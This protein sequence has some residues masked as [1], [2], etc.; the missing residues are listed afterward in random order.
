MEAA[1]AGTIE[2]YDQS[3]KPFK[4][5]ADAYK[6]EAEKDF[7]RGRCG[8]DWVKEAARV[9]CKLTEWLG[10]PKIRDATKEVI[11][12]FIDWKL[13]SGAAPGTVN[14]YLKHLS[15]ILSRAVDS[16]VI[17]RHP[18]K[19]IKKPKSNPEVGILTPDELQ[20]LLSKATSILEEREPWFALT[21]T[22]L[23][24]LVWYKPVTEVAKEMGYQTWLLAS[25]VGR[26]A[27][28]LIQKA[29]VKV[30]RLLLTSKPT[31]LTGMTLPIFPPL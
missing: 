14:T 25:A 20:T 6:D 3:N 1:L 27:R 18:M 15:T 9:A 30:P 22:E 12:D 16:G 19:R 2:Y 7:K 23:Q 5:Y 11:Q 31:A 4:E 13:D 17:N 10:N 29:D 24:K 26:L 8:Q 28:C 21:D